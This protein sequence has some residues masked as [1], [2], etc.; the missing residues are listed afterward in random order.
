MTLASNVS[1]VIACLGYAAVVPLSY[2]ALV[3]DVSRRRHG[4]SAPQDTAQHDRVSITRAT[5]AL[6]WTAAGCAALFVI[7]LGWP[8]RPAYQAFLHGRDEPATL[9]ELD[10]SY[11]A[12]PAETNAATQYIAA[13]D[14]VDRDSKQFYAR[15]AAQRRSEK[16][17]ASSSENINPALLIVGGAELPSAGPIRDDDWKM[18]EAY[19]DQVTSHVA[20]TLEKLAADGPR[21]SRYPIDLREGFNV[22]LPHL[23][24]LRMLAREL[25]L[26]ALHWSVAGDSKKAQDA[27]LALM[28]LQA[29]LSNEP[30][31]ISQLV[32]IAILGIAVDSVET[33]VNRAPLTDDDL[34]RLEQRLG[35][36]LPPHTEEMILDKAMHGECAMSLAYAGFAAINNS[37]LPLQPSRPSSIDPSWLFSGLAAPPVGDRMVLVYYYSNLVQN[38]RKQSDGYSASTDQS[39]YLVGEDTY[40][41]APTASLLAPAVARAYEAEWRIRMQLGMAQAALAAQRFRLAQGHL[42]K[43]LTELVPTYLSEV[44][45]DC[46]AE[47]GQAVR[48]VIR[49]DGTFVVYSI[50]RNGRDED[51]K[52]WKRDNKSD[53]FAFTVAP[54]HPVN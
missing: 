48:Y 32:R 37:T 15:M 17:D 29:S 23:A 16:R 27:V 28:P 50:G 26:D 40:F 51:G 2:V 52:N 7:W 54:R 10:A 33:V 46:Y 30:I 8:A 9:A 5:R 38:V 18:A 39:D 25:H 35:Q 47:H 1:A 11:P 34:Q 21:P 3:L 45:N 44:P 22:K 20:P 36:A 14:V 19:W 43:D 41:I 24:R 4:A 6:A 31:L 13:A 12:V 49:K 53:D 42:P